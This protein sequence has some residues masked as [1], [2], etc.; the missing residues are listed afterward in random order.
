MKNRKLFLVLLSLLLAAYILSACSSDS[1]TEMPTE[2]VE[3]TAEMV[4][5]TEEA[6]DILPTA[7]P[8]EAT[9]TAKENLR[10]RSGPSQKY[11]IYS[12]M[13]GAETAKLLGISSDGTYYAI[14]VP[15]VAPNTGWVDVNFADI[16]NA[17]DLPVLESPPV[18]PTAEFVGPQEGDPTLVAAD[19]VFVRSGPGDQYPAYGIAEAGSKGLAIGVSEDGDWWV[20]RIDPQIIGTGYGW[21]LK[22]FVTTENLED[23]LAVI[24]TPPLPTTGQLPPPD[25]NGPYGVATHFINVRSGPGLNYPVVV[26]AAPGASGEISGKSADNAW[27]QVKVSTEYSADGLAWINAAYVRVFNVSGIQVVEAPPVPPTNPNPPD[28]TYSCVLV[29]QFPDDGTVLEAG[30]TFDMT[31]E[32]QNTSNAT[33]ST[34]NVV[35]SKVSATLDQP[36][37][38]IDTL[39]LAT[40]VLPSENYE[41][42][43]PMK[44][45]DFAG[46]FGEYW[47]LTQGDVTV[48]D[49][50]N[51]IQVQE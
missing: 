32:V 18:P 21:V 49:F 44:A 19:A 17:T 20:V 24:K 41:V 15:I 51:V 38:E 28:G 27:W 2:A 11:P 22:E 50:Y 6:V 16:S 7:A 45:P 9:L 37:S 8:G 35:I 33:W 14:E 29:S 25:P 48:C 1:A 3:P 26:V 36:L 46:E 4:E 10:V 30:M 31:W 5:P 42:T 34:E 13:A 23:A 40:D 43:V 39:T 47:I 12:K